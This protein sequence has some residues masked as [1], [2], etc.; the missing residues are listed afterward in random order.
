MK[1]IKNI[2][3]ATINNIIVAF[4]F[5]VI[6]CVTIRFTIGDEL[7]QAI[8]L[9]NLVSV[10]DKNNNTENEAIKIDL[11]NKNLTHYPAW[12]EKYGTLSIDSINV[13]LGLYYGDSLSILRKGVGQSVSYFPGEGGSILYMGHNS[14]K[15]FRRFSELQIGDEIKVTTT[16]G[17][18]NYKIYDMQLIKET[19]LDKVPIQRDEEILM[20]YTCYPFNNVGYATQRYVVYA[21]L[22][23]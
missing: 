9:I 16:Y 23:K 6:I 18:Y 1:K 4:I 5:I 19:D 7:M 17:E 2:L 8:A 22:E 14:K 15:V 11:E 12:G 21:K 10:S 13:K 20:V 3:G